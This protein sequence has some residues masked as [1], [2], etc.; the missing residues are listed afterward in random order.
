MNQPP[1]S[2][3]SIPIGINQYIHQHF[4]DD[5]LTDIRPV[6]NSKGENSWLVDVTHD[7]AIYHLVFDS[8][9]VLVENV[10]ENIEFP[11]EDVEIGEAD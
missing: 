1:K 6:K 5:F 7:S 9:G 11:G 10:I 4:K 2:I 3:E 8:K